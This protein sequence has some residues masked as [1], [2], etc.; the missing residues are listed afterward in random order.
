MSELLVFPI[1]LA[2]ASSFFPAVAH[3]LGLRPRPYRI[4]VLSQPE[5]WA[6]ELLPPGQVAALFVLPTSVSIGRALV[7]KVH[8]RVAFFGTPSTGTDHVE[9]TALEDAGIGFVHSPGANARSVVEYVLAALG[10][11]DNADAF[12]RGSLEVGI[13]GYG[14]IG[15]G[16]GK[17][18]SGAGIPFSFFDPFVRGTQSAS[19]EQVLSCPIVT[20]HVPLS[21]S[22][23]HP[24]YEMLNEALLSQIP[25]DATVLNTSRG[26]IMSEAVFLQLTA[27]CRCIID[28]FPGEPPRAALVRAP[29]WA[30][31]HVAGYNYTARLAGCRMLAE[32]FLALHG[33]PE[34]LDDPPRP[35]YDHSV[36]DFLPS[37]SLILK[38]APESFSLRRASYPAR[39]DFAAY[40][41]RH[42]RLPPGALGTISEWLQAT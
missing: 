2:G 16:L 1:D 33:E 11:L 24:T 40:G 7:E 28:V 15:G 26:R 35:T 3:R 36:V 30:S 13:V 4:S 20:F 14:R 27:R 12:V 18:L 10:N 8:G 23:S 42:G 17:I 41:L 34:P 9:P 5:S 29:F 37:E 22:G 31:P 6:D 38:N 39:G 19:L 21:R 25:R 32:A